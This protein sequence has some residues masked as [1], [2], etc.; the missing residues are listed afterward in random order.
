MVWPTLHI[1]EVNIPM[2]SCIH[3]GASTEMFEFD[4]PIC[5][6]CAENGEN[7]ASGRGQSDRNGTWT[8]LPGGRIDRESWY[9]AGPPVKE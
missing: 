5:I 8:K 9:P 6:M 7:G 4:E 1:T 2:P 3:C